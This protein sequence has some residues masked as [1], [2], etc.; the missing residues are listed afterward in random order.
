M[1]MSRRVQ[2]NHYQIKINAFLQEKLCLYKSAILCLVRKFCSILR[3]CF[4]K[5][6]QLKGTDSY[7]TG[8]NT[9]VAYRIIKST[10]NSAWS[11]PTSISKV[12]T[13]YILITTCRAGQNSHS[14]LDAG[15]ARR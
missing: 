15:W 7:Y 12:Q 3:C 2:Q 13:S 10:S 5:F 9:T 6:F 4:F 1:T 11:F 8:L 14:R